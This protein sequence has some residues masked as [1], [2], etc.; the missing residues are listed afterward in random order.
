MKSS[1][2][3]LLLP[4]SVWAKYDWQCNLYC[5]NGGECRHGKGKFGT[6]ADVDGQGTTGTTEEALPWESSANAGFGMYCACPVGFTGLQCEIAMNVCDENENTCYNGNACARETAADGTIWWRC[7]CDASKSVLTASYAIKYCEHVATVFCNKAKNDFGME[8]KS[9]CTNGGKCEE[10]D[11]EGQ[12]KV[13]CICLEGFE[14]SHC[15]INN[16]KNPLTFNDL[17][18]KATSN[19]SA[20]MIVGI[21]LGV[22]AC[23]IGV[24][25]FRDKKEKRKIRRK[26]RLEN[27]GI[28][29]VSLS[30]SKFPSFRVQQENAEVI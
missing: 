8:Q 17:T 1:L 21:V 27:A 15:E 22:C 4:V 26:Q 13:G 24:M 16:V 6:Y 29:T 20:A 7:E 23:M 11:H 2:L 14:G 3:R 10:K 5:Y 18:V 28:Q 19:A 25:V 12:K 30:N 9:Y